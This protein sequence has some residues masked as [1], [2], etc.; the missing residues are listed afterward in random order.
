MSEVEEEI[1]EE[2]DMDC[3]KP[4]PEY[5]NCDPVECGKWCAEVQMKKAPAAHERGTIINSKS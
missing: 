4:C 1:F 5:P 3:C 2:P